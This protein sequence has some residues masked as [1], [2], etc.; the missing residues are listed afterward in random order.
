MPLK[1]IQQVHQSTAVISFLGLSRSVRVDPYAY[2][3]MSITV[4]CGGGH[5]EGE[6]P[7]TG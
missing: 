4:P 7:H 1:P 3:D 6:M 5:V 2:V